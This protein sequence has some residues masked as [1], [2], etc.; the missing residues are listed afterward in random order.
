MCSIILVAKRII[1]LVFQKIEIIIDLTFRRGCDFS[2]WVEMNDIGF[3]EIKGN[4]YQPS[5]VNLDRIIR[6]F[7]Q[8]TKNDSIIDIGCGKGYAMYRMHNL[9]FG[10]IDGYDLN[11]DLVN[12]ANMNF[13]KLGYKNC[14]AVC[15]DAE[16]FCDYDRYNYF[17]MFNAVPPNVF[18][19]MLNNIENSLKRCPRDAF[20][21]LSNPECHE[22]VCKSKYF[23]VDHRI[24][25]VISWMNVICYK[26]NKV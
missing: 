8:I 20:L 9:D 11:P 15:A 13:K 2:K 12:I 6:K 17:Y 22:T 10:I 7:Y 1:G 16:S 23:L 26:A 5:F 21:I 19:K 4:K 3:S 14:R 24:K 25:G 18:Q